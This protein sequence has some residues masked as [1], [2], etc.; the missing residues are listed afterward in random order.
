M[1][2]TGPSGASPTK[3]SGGVKVGASSAESR[4]M[5]VSDTVEIAGVPESEL[6]PKVRN[7]LASLMSQIQELRVELERMRGRINEL[8]EL[9]DTDPL[10]GIFNRRAFIRELNRA[11]AMA[12][13][14]EAPSSLIFADV[15]NLKIVNDRLGHAA[16]DAA[17]TH[18]ASVL[19]KNIRR[20]DAVGRLGGDEFGVL[21]AQTTREMAVDKASS[22]AELVKAE[23]V[24]WRAG[25]FTTSIACGVV[26]VT[27]CSTAEAALELADA[28]MYDIKK[29]R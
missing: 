13:R 26:E 5:S 20:S 15:N 14:Y 7:A 17:L 19:S 24:N 25:A 27:K 10:V 11:L 29:A 6:T 21:L 1:K 28:A 3:K 18:V 4:R 16:G 23:P 12:E 8:E 9:A 22:L 2:I